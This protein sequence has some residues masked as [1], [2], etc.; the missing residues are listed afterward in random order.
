MKK[1]KLEKKNKQKL[2]R[3]QKKAAKKAAA[4]SQ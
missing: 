2:P 1:T 4:L 3:R